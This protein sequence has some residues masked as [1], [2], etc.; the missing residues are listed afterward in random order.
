MAVREF[1]MVDVW[2]VIM[3]ERLKG[4][5]EVRLFSGENVSAWW[6]RCLRRPRVREFW[7]GLLSLEDIKKR[8]AVART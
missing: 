4:C 3:V 2:Y 8:L 6:E 1:N 5:G 7:G